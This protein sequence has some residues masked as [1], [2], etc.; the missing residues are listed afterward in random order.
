MP[1]LE[2]QMM[3]A[4]WVTAVTLGVALSGGVYVSGQS[5]AG[6]ASSPKALSRVTRLD[7]TSRR[8]AFGGKSFGTAGAYEILMGTAHAV[9][10]PKAALNAGIVDLDKAPRNAAGLVE[11]SFD[12]QILKPVDISKGNGT[13]LYEINNRS[14]RPLYGYWDEGGP[15]YEADNAGNG[16]LMNNGYTYVASGWMHGAKSAANPLQ[17]WASL[18]IAS[19][20][21]RPITGTAMEEWME[22]GTGAF[23]K[24]SYPAAS[25]DQAKATLTYR[26]HQND[27]RQTLPAAQWSYVNDTTVKFTPPAGTD[28]GTIYEFVYEAKD[29]VVEG[30]GFAGMRDFVS[31]MRHSPADETGT[32]NPL[33]VN[34]QPVLR[35]AVA[36]GAS[37][38][39]RVVRDFIYQGF[40]QDTAGRRVFESMNA[41]MAGARRTFTNYRFA[42]PGRWTRQHEDHPYPTSEFP[43]TFDKTTDHLTGKSDGLL[44]KCSA[45][46]TCPNVIQVDSYA[47][48]YGAHASLVVTDT[49]GKALQLPASVRLYLLSLSHNQG[50][51]GCMDPANKV[52]P[53]PYYRAALQATVRWVRDGVAPPPTRAPSVADGTLVTLAEQGKSYPTIPDRPFN[54][55]IS[56]VGVRDFSV[57]PP[58]ENG[59][60]TIL[61]PKLDRDGNM[62]AGVLV[63]EVAVPIATYGKAV[64]KKGFGEGDLCG[65]NGATIAFAKTKAERLASGDSRLSVEERYPGGQGEYAQKYGRAVDKLVA[66]GYLLAEDGTKLKTAASLPRGTN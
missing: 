35:L 36:A 61:V 42:Q 2:V 4:R 37:Q 15:G 50:D 53:N 56:E 34:G 33:F 24:L 31:F 20:N 64:R 1:S 11:Y 55:A 28:A 54:S 38:S 44:I 6:S 29:S 5:Q 66:E 40:N 62:T 26:E 52:S 32:A 65:A 46:N 12:V 14:N 48:L 10:D 41:D 25:L 16:F 43:F 13:L 47:E 8:P 18:P 21:G 17:L 57:F 27:A 23:G 22:P 45:S 9:A 63:P 7:I 58:K 19:N 3:L 49:K 30:L 51:A 39:G 60:Y 59:K